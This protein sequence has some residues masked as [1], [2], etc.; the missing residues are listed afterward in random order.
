MNRDA[1]D[2]LALVDAEK[3]DAIVN[4]AAQSEVAPSWD[5]PEHWFQTNVVALS[6]LVNDLRR[7]IYLKRYL[8]IS[9]PEVYGTCVGT[10][11]E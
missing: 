10:V 4:F 6:R 3:P 8:H 1:G 9:S 5:H 7:R 2:L 11:F